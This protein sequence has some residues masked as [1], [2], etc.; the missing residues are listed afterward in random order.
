MIRSSRA[1]L[2]AFTAQFCLVASALAAGET[3]TVNTL[4]DVRDFSGAQQ[5]ADLPGADGKTSFREACIAA[6]NTPGAQ[7]I[8][9]AI[10]TAEYWLVD[11]VAVLELQQSVFVIGDDNTTIDFTTQADFAGD[12]NPNGM[13]VGIYGLEVNGWGAPA[14]SLNADNCVIKGLGPV[15]A[16]GSGVTINGNNNRVIGCHII[17]PQCAV[18]VGGAFSA[19]P[20]TGNIIG[21]V[22]PGE[23]NYLAGGG[24]GV[25]ILT[26]SDQTTVIGNNITAGDVAVWIAGNI[27]T[28]S[29]TNIQIGGPTSAERNIIG[30]ASGYCCEGYPDGIQIKIE[31]AEFVTVENNYVGVEADGATPIDAT[32]AATAVQI[33]NSTNVTFHD[34]VIS[35]TKAFGINHFAGQE[36]G[37]ALAIFGACDNLLVTGNRIGTDATG[38]IAIRNHIGIAVSPWSGSPSPQGLVIADN[39]VANSD[40][41]GIQI[42]G[43]I[44]GVDLR[45]NVLFDNTLLGIDLIAHN[46]FGVTP[47]DPGDADTGANELQ[48]YPVLSTAE[49]GTNTQVA[50]TLSSQANKTY[51]IEFFAN[52]ACDPSGFGEAERYLGEIQVTTAASGEA[53]FDV[54]LPESTSVGEFVTATATDATGNTSELSACLEVNARTADLNA[55]GAVDS[56]DLN[57]LLNAFSSCDGDTNY[58]PLYDLNGSGCIDGSDLN[59]LLSNWG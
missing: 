47:N 58:T 21:G 55:D 13:E 38:M 50:G 18:E 40:L 56:A 35:N 6:T 12:T 59:L 22:A 24:S 9:F 27:Y 54:E 19:S 44:K 4:Y 43:A 17:G 15:W 30:G 16:R 3:I 23:G 26:P 46:N 28:G 57:L 51:R 37:T 53:T 8:T 41:T 32:G 1:T 33:R 29:P 20:A 34:N 5:V 25:C 49:A 48:N 14:I 10:P 39:L 31:L 52:T 42:S 45:R 11:D 36:F 2:T 7:T